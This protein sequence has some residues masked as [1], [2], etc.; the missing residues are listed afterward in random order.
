MTLWW[1]HSG[2]P[3]N[4]AASVEDHAAIVAAIRA[5][6]ADA[7]ASAAERHSRNETQYL[8]QPL[9]LKVRPEEGA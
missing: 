5:R 9:S 6:D 4:D 2:Q 1:G 8:I 3:G 7:A